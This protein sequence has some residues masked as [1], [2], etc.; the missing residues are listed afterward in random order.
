M[1]MNIKIRPAS[2]NDAESLLKIYKPYI[3]KTA[4]TFEYDVPTVLEFSDR[5]KNIKRKYP[6]IVAES[7]ENILGYAYA[8][9][10]KDR[11]AYDWAVETSIYVKMNARKIGIGSALYEKLEKLLKTQ[12]FLNLNA[13]IAYTEKNDEYL[14]NDSVIFH[15]KYGYELVGK[16]RKCGFKF[17]K[18]YDMVWMEKFIGEHNDNPNEIIPFSEVE[19][20]I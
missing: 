10:F 18:W 15:K 5:I 14:T 16:F 3:E 13:C 19:I 17:G 2:E 12:G 6:Y 4:I 1:D 7:E 20:D 11:K 9:C 8:S